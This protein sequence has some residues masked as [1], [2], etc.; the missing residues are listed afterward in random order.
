MQ[1]NPK[2]IM[3]IT[4]AQCA[5]FERDKIGDGNGIGTCNPFHEWLNKF[6]LRRPKPSDYDKAF[7][8][9]GDKVFYPNIER[10]CKKFVGKI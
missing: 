9:L 8:D 5:N 4:C 6:P 1:F 2:K 10:N 3:L 7:M